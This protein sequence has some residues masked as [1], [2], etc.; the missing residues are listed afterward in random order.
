M[1]F[2]K[3]TKYAKLTF[4]HLHSSRDIPIVTLKSITLKQIC[5]KA[6]GIVACVV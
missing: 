3:K 1:I 6:K 5:N 4:L 2:R